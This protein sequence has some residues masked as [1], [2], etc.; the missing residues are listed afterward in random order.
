[1][2]QIS[3]PMASLAVVSGDKSSTYLPANGFGTIATTALLRSGGSVRRPASPRTSSTN[4]KIRLI[5]MSAPCRE[6]RDQ[7]I[8]ASQ[9][10]VAKTIQSRAA[11][12]VAKAD[13]ALAVE[14][15]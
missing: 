10:Y 4:V 1:M 11:Q 6:R 14:L 7:S 5:S 12:H 2:A 3:R 13:P 15:G 9:D 8:A